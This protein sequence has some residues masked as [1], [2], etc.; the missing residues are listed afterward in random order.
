MKK[1]FLT[2]LLITAVF[3]HSGCQD[4][5]KIATYY[6][7]DGNANSYELNIS[8]QLIRYRPINE[9]LS[10]SGA[11]SGGKPWEVKISK[12]QMTELISAIKK[13]VDNQSIH[14]KTRP[15]DSGTIRI[16]DQ[17]QNE[18]NKVVIEGDSEE[19]MLIGGLLAEFIN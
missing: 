13:A 6:Y 10:S 12:Q 16:F 17:D 3:I 18:L 15:K 7:I 14:L 5:Q 4:D 2:I 11:Y 9:E 8:D 1:I 19:N